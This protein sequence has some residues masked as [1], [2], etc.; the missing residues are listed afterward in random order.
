MRRSL[1][2]FQYPMTLFLRANRLLVHL[3]NQL[4]FMGLLMFISCAKNYEEP[5]I[6]LE[7]YVLEEGFDL[8]VV[9]SEPFLTAPVAIDFDAKG[10]IWVA[11][12]TDFM[13][14]IDGTGEEN[15]TGAIKI[16][17]DLDNDGVVDHSTNFLAQLH[18]PRALALVYE[19]LLYAEP[20]NL[21][22]V[23]IV[24]DRPGKRTLVDSLYAASGNPEHMANGLKMNIDNWIYN[25][26]S[27][28]RYRR[29]AGVWHK[30]PT[31]FRGQWG[32]SEDNFGRLYYNNNSQQ[33]RGDY[34]LPNQLIRNPY[35]IP[36]TGQNQLLTKDQ[37]VYP[38][39]ANPVNRGYSKGTLNQDSVLVNVTAACGPL[40]YRGGN[41]P[42]DYAQNAFVCIPE[43]NLIKR[44]LLFFEADSTYA[45]Q[46]WQG[47]EFLSSTD[48]GFRPVN[49]NNGPDGSMYIVDMHRGII[50]HY[51]F[52]TPYL[53]EKSKHLRLD[54]IVDF[55]R[56]LKVSSATKTTQNLV[57][58]AALPVNKLLTQLSDKNGWIRSKAQQEIIN[59]G[60]T[61]A[62]SELKSLALRSSSSL[63]KIHATYA[64][65]GL[66]A[67]D[68]DFLIRLAAQ[69]HKEVTAHCLV[70][71]AGF[72]DEDTTAKVATLFTEL[73]KKED[74]FIDLYLS[75]SVGPWAAVAPEVF[76]PI[77]L[78][79]Y[80]S[81][82]NKK[83]FKTALLS[84]SAG[85]EQHWIDAFTTPNNS[86]SMTTSLIDIIKR[87]KE[88]KPNWIYNT[89]VRKE[90][91]RTAGAK[92]FRQI[93]SACHGQAGGGIDGIG[94]PLENS[95]YM[96]KPIERLALIM[97]HG[98]KGSTVIDGKTY[99]EHIAMPGLLNNPDLSNEDLAN[100]MAYITNAFAND[101]QTLSA[102]SIEEL[103]TVFPK[104]GGEFT[105]EE[106]ALK[107]K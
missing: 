81:Y 52:L 62:I 48:L 19:G 59:R 54:T 5:T 71:L 4:I 94:P 42:A 11:E 2:K 74:V 67:L 6:S 73:R 70:L 107:Y 47:K 90:D 49:L 20:P 58:L 38:T 98:L 10:R 78:D 37:R 65:E 8:S 104:D 3:P 89:E 12:M 43:A 95:A 82:P 39:V 55:G 21:Y 1:T 25:A 84:G 15:N 7:G 24:N 61:E 77:A 101:S 29:I 40:I 72:I 91:N 35:Y 100:I 46:A 30:E 36:T 80:R 45:E 102:K 9:A 27:N 60:G 51:A 69:D 34:L 83:I 28:F 87:S 97:L 93:C 13:Q 53:K 23:E 63:A 85:A 92:L 16:L 31:V 14:N 56:I 26:N 22:F 103:R 44:N 33:L 99:G 106:L 76:T 64:L 18:M 66:A 105:R 68:A 57:D 88:N 50:Q 79:L 17:E 41:F 96:K 32:I 86:G 75:T